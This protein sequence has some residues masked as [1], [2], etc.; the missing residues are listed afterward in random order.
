[1]EVDIIG[2]M[3]VRLY[4]GVGAYRWFSPKLDMTTVVW[5][6]LYL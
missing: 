5:R 3:F 6:H 2:L 4:G 1:M